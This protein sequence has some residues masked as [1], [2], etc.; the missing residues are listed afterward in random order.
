MENKLNKEIATL[1]ASKDTVKVLST[2]DANGNPH[3][4][5]KNSLQI[6]NDNKLIFFELIESSISNK[7]VLRALWFNKNISILISSSNGDSYQIKGIPVKTLISGEEFENYY[8]YV[9]ENLNNS[10]LAAVWIIE[11]VEVINQGYN[12]RK[13]IEEKKHPIFKHL[14]QIAIKGVE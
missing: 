11:P 5:V 14:D 9:K 13:A 1:I 4:V 12:A 7:N 6:D 10:D 3:S 8:R 2:I